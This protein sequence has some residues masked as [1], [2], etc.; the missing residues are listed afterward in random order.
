M[1]IGQLERFNKTIDELYGRN[2]QTALETLTN[3]TL[4]MGGLT[5]VEGI[6]IEY[7]WSDGSFLFTSAY[8]D[9]IEYHW[10]ESKTP[11]IYT[12]LCNTFP[13]FWKTRGVQTFVTWGADQMAKDVIQTRG[14]WI[15]KGTKDRTKTYD[16]LEWDIRGA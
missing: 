1:A 4:R 6:C 5:G 16:T 13:I 15:D 9:R 3:A 11:G 8:A 10:L 2:T 12:T 14:A 7:Y